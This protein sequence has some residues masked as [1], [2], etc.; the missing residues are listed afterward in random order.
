MNK[1][2]FL[3]IQEDCLNLLDDVPLYVGSNSEQMY[4]DDLKERMDKIQKELHKR[5]E[6]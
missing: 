4:I 6:E 5:Q 1:E 3:K 2:K